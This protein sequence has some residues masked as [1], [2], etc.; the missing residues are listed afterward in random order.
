[1]N[2]ITF[3]GDI[4]VAGVGGP[5]SRLYA[6]QELDFAGEDVTGVTLTLQE[7][8][9][10]AGKIV[11]AGRTLTAPADLSR[12]S[13]ALVPAGPRGILIGPPIAE[14]SPTG[15]FT[16]AGVM[17]GKYR[18]TANVPGNTGWTLKSSIIDGRDTLDD[19][20]EIKAGQNVSGAVL[21]FTDQMAELSGRLIDAAGKPAP[22]FTILLFSTDRAYWPTGSRRVPPPI[23]PAS[24]G[25]FR[26]TGLPSGEYYLAAVTDLDPQDWGDPA[27]MDQIVPGAIKITIGDG[28]KKVQDLKVGGSS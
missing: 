24:D 21:T 11:F 19:S 17:P 16:M 26:A 20:L 5:G 2:A 15:E 9:T 23:Q 28:E 13:I 25:K 4:F 8:M 6:Q 14:I 10:V 12:M 7:G 22:G 1:V 27:F 18:L 3:G